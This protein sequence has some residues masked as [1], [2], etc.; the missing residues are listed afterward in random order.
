MEYQSITE[1]IVDPKPEVRKQS[2]MLILQLSQDQEQR[3]QF[4]NTELIKNLSKL[5][6]DLECYQTVLSV[7]IQFSQDDSFCFEFIKQNFIIKISEELKQRMFQFYKQQQINEQDQL[8]IQLSLLSLN[9]L[10]QLDQ[11]KE[12]FLQLEQQDVNRCFYYRIFCNFFTDPRSK[13]YFQQFK[14]IL[15]NVTSS[16]PVRLE[17][18]LKSMKMIQFFV[19]L[20][21]TGEL[22]AIQILKNMLFEYEQQELIDQIVD[23]QLVDNVINFIA[24]D[25]VLNNHLFNIDQ[26]EIGLQLAVLQIDIKNQPQQFIQRIHEAIKCLLIL[27]NVDFLEK[28][29]EYNR[30]K[31]DLVLR[32]LKKLDCLERDQL[33]VV[34]TIYILAK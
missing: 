23:Y 14:Q 30:D 21:K 1:F 9:N 17:L 26:N 33:E 5:I 6:G 18:L 8:I 13:D 4:L 24:V 29:I 2:L 12:Q 3:S 19:N 25:I 22:F 34:E 11:G 31:L 15:I 7:I 16:G 27:T 10:T 20:L 32:Q 28:R